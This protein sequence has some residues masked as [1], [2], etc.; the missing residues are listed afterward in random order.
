[1]SGFVTLWKKE[2]RVF[3]L[4]PLAYVLGAMFLLVMG[5]SF[6]MLAMVLVQG[7]AGVGVMQALFASLF[8]WLAVLVVVPMLTMRMLADEKRSGTI[9]LLMTAPVTDAAVVLAKYAAA[10]TVYALM[11]LPTLA[12]VFILHAFSP[13]TAPIDLAPVA[14]AYFGALLVGV[15]YVAV[16]IFTSALTSNQ[17]VA[18]MISFAVFIL[19]FFFGLLGYVSSGPVMQAAT[20]YLSP[21]NHMENF[22]IGQF[23]TRPVVL[24]LSGAAFMLFAAVKVVESRR[25]K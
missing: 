18:A 20:A 11:W 7:P 15:L 24:Y 8:F 17:L 13:L 2:L 16:G 14:G 9:E 22:S 21:V 23:D 6:W 19:F 10:L 5:F 4:S 3:F 1:M 25:W 12:Y